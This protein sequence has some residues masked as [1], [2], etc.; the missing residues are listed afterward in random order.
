MSP[1]SFNILWVLCVLLLLAAFVLAI[2]RRRL[3]AKAKALAQIQQR[4]TVT[5]IRSTGQDVR[6]HMPRTQNPTPQQPIPIT[7]TTNTTTIQPPPP[8]FDREE[9]PPPSYQDYRKDVLVQSPR[10]D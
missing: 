2:R 7:A 9:P 1:T 6:I 5:F 3:A 4:D 8:A 10:N